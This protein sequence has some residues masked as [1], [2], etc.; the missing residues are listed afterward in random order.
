MMQIKNRP[1]K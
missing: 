1:R